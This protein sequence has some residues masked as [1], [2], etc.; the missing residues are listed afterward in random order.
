MHIRI[1]QLFVGRGVAENANKNFSP[2]FETPRPELRDRQKSQSEKDKGSCRRELQPA[3]APPLCPCDH[4]QLC[5]NHHSRKR[6]S[7]SAGFLLGVEQMAALKRLLK[8]SKEYRM[9]FSKQ[10]AA[11]LSA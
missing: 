10:E 8:S 9:A 3:A 2:F 6:G 5:G 7:V 1:A 4:A 11:T